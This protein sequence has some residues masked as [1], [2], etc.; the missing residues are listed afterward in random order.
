MSGTVV[1][2]DSELTQL[3]DVLARAGSGSAATALISGESGCGKT[4]LLNAVAEVAQTDG[5]KCLRLQGVE[6]EA[7][8]SGAGLLSLL[9]PLRGG[10]DSVPEAQAEAL[11]AALGWGPAGESGDRFLIGAATLSLLAAES[12]RTP[13]LINVDDVQWVDTESADAL[14]LRRPST[15]T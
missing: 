13:L 9:S 7:V 8:L 10:L 6:S 4:H 14:G 11:S 15:R 5:W 1:G 2:R 3:G 12:S